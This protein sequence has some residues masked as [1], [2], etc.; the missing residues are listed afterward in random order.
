MIRALRDVLSLLPAS[1]LASDRQLGRLGARLER[2]ELW[3]TDVLACRVHDARRLGMAVGERC[4][5]YSLHVASEAELV[6]IGD[7]VIVSGE[8]MFITHDGAL[9]T[10]SEK[11]PDVNG[12]YGRIRIGNRC[13]LGLRSMILPG[14]EL[15]D[16]C[17][18]AAGAVVMDSFA[19]N[20]VIAGNPATYV[21]PASM[22]L[23]MKRG[24]ANTV[25]DGDYRFPAKLP[26]ERL[27]EA[28]RTIPFRPVRRRES[29]VASQ[30]PAIPP[31]PVQGAA[32]NA[33]SLRVH[34]S[35]DRS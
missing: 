21:C 14:V 16:D 34:A 3:R 20:S 11:F 31:V 15:G 22:Y 30:Q 25:Y 29:R 28:M 32:A 33:P 13:F 35:N 1:W 26:P 5:L 4:R 12:H 6:E 19:P 9:F 2:G 10:A 17:I 18:V 24:S 27:V 7:D 8:V 23:D